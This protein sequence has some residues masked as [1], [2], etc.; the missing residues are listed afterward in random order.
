M[1]TSFRNDSSMIRS[2]IGR[3]FVL[4]NSHT[5]KPLACAPIKRHHPDN[6]ERLQE[7]NLQVKLKAPVAGHV[8]FTQPIDQLSGELY[9]T[10]I[11]VEVFSNS[12]VSQNNTLGD[13][14]WHLSKGKVRK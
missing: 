10:Q 13:Y 12:K 14:A 2:V 8:T 6:G 9:P 1:N 7:I 4:Y 3:S 11:L 5:G